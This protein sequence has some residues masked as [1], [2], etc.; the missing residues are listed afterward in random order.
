MKESTKNS[1]IDE[2]SDHEEMEFQEPTEKA[3]SSQSSE[4]SII[5]YDIVKYRSLSEKLSE[6]TNNDLL[7]VLMTRGHDNGNPFLYNQSRYLYRSINFEMNPRQ[8]FED[9]PNHGRG[10]GGFSRG[11][12]RG[13]YQNFRQH[14]ESQEETQHQQPRMGRHMQSQPPTPHIARGRSVPRNSFY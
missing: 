3:K 14:H 2:I 11:G 9:R 13:G 10:R 4:K 5:D 1:N 12:G 8:A 6:Y 7:R